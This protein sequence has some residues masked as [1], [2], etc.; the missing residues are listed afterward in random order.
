MF[1]YLI[2]IYDRNYEDNFH[3]EAGGYGM[4]D[5]Q[6]HRRGGGQDRRGGGGDRYDPFN[7]SSSRGEDNDR[8]GGGGDYPSHSRRRSD[9]SN[10]QNQNTSSQQEDLWVRPIFS[11]INFRSFLFSYNNRPTL[12]MM[13][14]FK[15]RTKRGNG[16]KQNHKSRN[17]LL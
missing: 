15:R 13:K 9:N 5:N 16:Q 8:R 17:Q 6:Q 11:S 10:F 1:L 3:D 7:P 14:S 2:F 12:I 4:N